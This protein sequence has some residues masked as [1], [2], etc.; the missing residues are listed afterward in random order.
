MVIHHHPFFIYVT[1]SN[2]TDLHISCV[3]C[4][5]LPPASSPSHKVQTPPTSY[6]SLP[7]AISPSHQ[8][9]RTAPEVTQKQPSARFYHAVRDH[10]LIQVAPAPRRS[11]PRRPS[12]PVHG[13][14]QDKS[15]HSKS[16]YSQEKCLNV[17]PVHVDEDQ[18]G[19]Q[20]CVFSRR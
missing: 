9:T 20:S 2:N 17:R 5:P 7:P 3:F 8:L 11:L 14:A 12:L 13:G 1:I 16:I 10:G 19:T 15:P 4:K 6:K 18:R